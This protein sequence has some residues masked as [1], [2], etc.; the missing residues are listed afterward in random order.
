MRRIRGDVRPERGAVAVEAGLVSTVLMP[1]LLGVLVFGN[2][3]WHAQRVDA[4]AVRIP[5]GA[6]QGSGLTCQELV[7]RVKATVV[8]NAD[9]LSG[10]TGI[11]LGDV[12]AQV[13][14]VLPAVGAVVNVS[15]R[16]PVASTLASMLPDHG[17]VVTDTLVRLDDVT[18]S[19]QS[20]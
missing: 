8:Q 19:T 14:Q 18:L 6:I 1:L 13:V 9:N 16:V 10:T 5:S 7:D 3:L 12:T 2:Y 15:V 11:D 4:Y 20:C 17:A